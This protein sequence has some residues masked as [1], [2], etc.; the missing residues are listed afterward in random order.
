MIYVLPPL[1]VAMLAYMA[2]RATARLRYDRVRNQRASSR[3]RHAFRAKKERVRFLLSRAFKVGPD[4]PPWQA[5]LR[6][7]LDEVKTKRAERGE[8]S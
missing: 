1:V 8:D 6:S 4:E 3:G 5:E 7:S 2:W